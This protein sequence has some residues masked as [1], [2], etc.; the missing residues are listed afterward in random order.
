MNKRSHKILVV[1]D[2]VKIIEVV[3]SLLENMGFTVF[4]AENGKHALEIFD[5]ENLSLILLDL[6]LPDM[7]GE[8]VCSVIRQKSRIPIIMLTAKAGEESMVEGFAVGSDDYI[9][10]PFTLRELQA[11]VEAVLR[12]SG[13]D[14]LPL[15]SKNSFNGGDLEIDFESHTI[16]KSQAIVNLTPNEFNILAALIKYPNKVFTREGLIETAF[17]ED[18][19]GFD[20]TVDSH[21]KNLRQKIE[22]DPRKPIYVVTVHGV[23][24]RFGGEQIEKT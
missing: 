15:Y 12:R 2:E 20:R 4:V 13:N 14:L 3:K 5:R 9:T 22:S 23:G 21:I 10:K 8:N 17:G 7:P 16:K 6:M 24:Y 1:D 19:D 18:F 11:R